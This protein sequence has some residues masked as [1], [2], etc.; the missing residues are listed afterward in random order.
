MDDV[1]NTA[2]PVILLVHNN[3]LPLLI[4][5][6]QWALITSIM[7]HIGEGIPPCLFLIMGYQVGRQ[8]I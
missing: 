3:V 2:Y 7:Y 4:G 6:S 1:Q 8:T 5:A